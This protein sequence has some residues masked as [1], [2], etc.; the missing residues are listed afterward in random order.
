MSITV[1]YIDQSG[2]VVETDHM[3]AIFDFVKGYLPSRY[4]ST[5]KPTIFFISHSHPDHYS[6]SVFAYRKTVVLSSDVDVDP[7]FNVCKVSDGDSLFVQGI[8]VKVFGSTDAGVSYYVS[9]QSAGIFHAGDLNLWHWKEEST[10]DE[11]SLATMQ[12]LNELHRIKKV[13]IDIAFFP[14]DARM[15]KEY[16]QG[17]REF[18][19]LCQPKHFFPMHFR[20]KESIESFYRWSRSLENTQVYM[21][22]KPNTIFTVK[23]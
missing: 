5:G 21:I 23:L 17:A 12:F 18:I 8:G 14:V 10:S 11:V 20:K 15:Q 7:L 13:D 2:Y 19:R 1:E 16:D 3:V 9:D 6:T 22:N 4:L